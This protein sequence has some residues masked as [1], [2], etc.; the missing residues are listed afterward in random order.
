MLFGWGEYAAAFAFFFLS[1][2]IPVRPPV[3][4]WLTAALSKRGFTLAYSAISLAALGWLIAAATRAPVVVL[5][6]WAPWQNAMTFAGM[7]LACG[8]AALAIGRPNPHSFGGARN[9]Y[10]DPAAPGIVGWVR[11]PLLAVLMIW[12]LAHIPP[13]GTL[14]LAVLFGLFA[15]FSLLGMRII[16]RRKRREMG[17][18][19]WS[20][21]AAGP[22]RLS[23]SPAGLLRLGI[24]AILY[25]VLLALHG[26][27]IGVAPVL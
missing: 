22:A 6:D 7:A 12:S 20:R 3:K 16:D 14:A 10:F 4:A 27:V 1:H 11:H 13:N 18:A 19:R 5:W 25:L 8:L 9:E 17:K 21:L 26:P 24:G 23:P 15:G 2:S